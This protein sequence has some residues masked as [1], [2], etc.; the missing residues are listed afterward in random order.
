MTMG[1]LSHR[2]ALITLGQRLVRTIKFD[3]LRRRQVCGHGNDHERRVV[4]RVQPGEPRTSGDHLPL[5]KYA[6]GEIGR[7]FGQSSLTR[8][9]RSRASLITKW[10]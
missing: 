6:R 10:P 5:S 7:R 9:R 3:S 1:K 8:S 2:V 4:V